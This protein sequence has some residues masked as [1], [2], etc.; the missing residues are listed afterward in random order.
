MAGR[1]KK[2]TLPLIPIRGL[3]IFPYMVLHF[4]VAREKSIM[5]LEKALVGNQLVFLTAQKD[6]LVENPTEDEIYTVGTISKVKQI[7]KLPGDN[8]RVLVEGMSRAQ[9]KSYVDWEPFIL[10]DI[11]EVKESEQ[12]LAQEFDAIM[13]QIKE[14]L[15]TFVNLNTKINSESIDSILAIEDPAQLADSIAS[16]LFF[17]IE[18]K[19]SILGEMSI[20]MRLE[21]TIAIL[22]REI[23]I[24]ELE[25]T[26]MNQTRTQ[27][28]KNQRDYFLR[29]QIKAIQS[30]LGE[31]M[32][33]EMDEY[34]NR[35]KEAKLPEE[36]NNKV[37]KEL[38]RL[39]KLSASSPETAVIKH[40]I[41]TVLD[42][43]WGKR[44]NE[45]TD[46]KKAQ[47]I[48]NQ[49]HYGLE[50]VKER[51]VEY[52]AVRQLTN[53]SKGTMICLVGPPGVGKTSIAKS[54]ARA[55]NRNYVRLSL[56]GVRDEA[57]IRGHR[58][59]YI[60]AMPGRII[61]AIMQAGSQNPL[62]L[63]DEIDKMGND[64]R[65]D[66]A[67]AMLE[68]L[69]SEQ[70]HSFRDHYLELPFDLSDVL[71]IT[72]ANTIDTIPL[73]LLD[74][75]EVIEIAGYTAL[76]KLNIA[77]R[78][79][80]PKQ[81]ELH[82]LKKQNLKI[83]PHVIEEIIEGYTREAGVRNL[84]REIANVCRKAAN[85][86]V[87]DD[88]KTVSITSGNLKKFLGAKRFSFDQMKEKDEIG[89]VT[90]LAW[91]RVGGDTLSIEVNVMDGTGR[92]ELTGSLGDVMKESAKAAISYI[93]SK[94]DFYGI[95]P[96]F[97]KTKDIHIHVPEGA[98]PKDGPSAG[99][100]MAT[101]LISA[102]T[103]RPA[104]KDVAMTGEITLRG[105][106]LP[107]GGLKSKLLA[108]YR[109]GIKT[110]IIP[111]ENKQNL[112]EIPDTVKDNIKIIPVSAI[113]KVIS[114]ALEQQ[115]SKDYQITPPPS[116]SVGDFDTNFN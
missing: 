6:V 75:M 19:Q 114:I 68:V 101:A 70:N 110:V 115:P 116:Q 26:I 29:E 30:E 105:R 72:T 99:I 52:L 94:A 92:V 57:D 102:L 108:A 87:S 33:E 8:V 39:E 45:D 67:S 41:D 12:P 11:I 111:L 38:S 46:I 59:T 42:L 51:I 83:E 82:G 49:D 69:D 20:K 74:R 95:N 90:G 22:S 81:L 85:A 106:V 64:F 4:D 54:L 23:E 65:G 55:V 43:P 18:D 3:V 61:T 53:N 7:L 25:R 104:F 60:G 5:A 109:A 44:T 47:D 1:R 62:V 88:R 80:F 35:I 91:T 2:H 13:R 78:Y 103:G 96:D 31:S 112:D 77:T 40:W 21:K 48:L 71:F 28:D 32:T 73:P 17:R 107:I 100:T 58:K 98:T 76:E 79:I 56:G 97:Y 93:R 113:E 84:E 27:M 89:V 86:I 37:L 15:D 34:K 50:K 9:I 36:A 10:A 66:P 16:N 24:I 14:L 63:L